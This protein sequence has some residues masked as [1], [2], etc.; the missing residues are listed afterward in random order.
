M[1]LLNETVLIVLALVAAHIGI[2]VW[3]RKKPIKNIRNRHVVV[4]GGSSGIGLWVAIHAVKQGAHVTIIAR[5]VTN[6]GEFRYISMRMSS[7]V[8]CQHNRVSIKQY[9]GIV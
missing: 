1:D 4:T 6:L 9:G 7:T 2:Y 3:L 5:N 8:R